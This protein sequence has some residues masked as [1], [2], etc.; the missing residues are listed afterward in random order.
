MKGY[1]SHVEMCKVGDFVVDLYES[2]EGHLAAAV[3][4]PVTDT[5]QQVVWL[6]QGLSGASVVRCDGERLVLRT[7]CAERRG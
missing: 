5:V 7:S 6:S 1:S 2:Q 3:V 4:D